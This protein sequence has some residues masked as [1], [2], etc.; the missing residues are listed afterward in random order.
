VCVAKTFRHLHMP[1]QGILRAVAG[2]AFG[3][4]FFGFLISFF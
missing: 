4:T 1:R 3:F 2:S